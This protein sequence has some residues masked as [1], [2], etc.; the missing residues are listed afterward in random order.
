MPE[1]TAETRLHYLGDDNWQLRNGNEELE[2]ISWPELR[3]SISWKAYC[4][5]DED[6]KRLWQDG[7]DNLTV[8]FILDRLESELRRTGILEGPR[9][10]PTTFAMMLVKSFVRFPS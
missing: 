10:E 1:I 4:F 9:P 8:N 3:Y 2:N 6:E 5:Q 7:S